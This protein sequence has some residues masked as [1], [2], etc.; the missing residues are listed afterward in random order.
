MGNSVI[1]NEFSNKQSESH[2][3]YFR[4]VYNSVALDGDKR[5]ERM[6]ESKGLMAFLTW[7]GIPT[8]LLGLFSNMDELKSNILFVAGLLMI[9]IRFCFWVYRV[10]QGNK[11]KNMELKEKVIKLKEIEM[12]FEFRQ[13]EL[14]KLELHQLERENELLIQQLYLKNNK[15][16]GEEPPSN[17]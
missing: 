9:I 12:D 5:I 14:K 15:L 8:T 16:N 6:A 11:L 1:K 17:N 2:T 4:S 10:I 13:R 3:D 7:L